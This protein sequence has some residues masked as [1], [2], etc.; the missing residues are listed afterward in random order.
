MSFNLIPFPLSLIFIVVFGVVIEAVLWK[1]RKNGSGYRWLSNFAL[2]AGTVIA[3]LT[4][5]LILKP[6]I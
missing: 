3:A 5:Y 2:V 1:L 6:L 4:L